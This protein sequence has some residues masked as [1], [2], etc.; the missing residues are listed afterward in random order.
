MVDPRT[1]TGILAYA[2]TV[3]PRLKPRNAEDRAAAVTAWANIL[4]DWL[5]LAIGREAIAR[6][7]NAGDERQ[8]SPAVIITYGKTV[9]AELEAKARREAGYTSTVPRQLPPADQIL[10]SEQLAPQI[11]SLRAMLKAKTTRKEARN[12]SSQHSRSRDSDS[13]KTR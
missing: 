2:S 13:P 10:T 1:A 9:K 11:Q 4:P 12:D 6:H 3:D 8:L 5:T 7:Q